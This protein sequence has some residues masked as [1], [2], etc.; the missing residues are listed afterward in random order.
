MVVSEEEKE[1]TK[2]KIDS[3]KLCKETEPQGGVPHTTNSFPISVSLPVHITPMSKSSCFYQREVTETPERSSKQ[4]ASE[5]S[6]DA[7]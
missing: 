1:A 7:A 6:K 4:C 5:P 2:G 3:D